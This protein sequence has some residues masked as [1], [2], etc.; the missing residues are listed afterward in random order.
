[1]T[2]V[3][4]AMIG[5]GD[6]AHRKSGPAFYLSDRSQLIAVTNR[7]IDKAHLFAS[8]HGNPQVFASVDEMLACDQ[9]DAVY[10]GT[11][12]Q[13]HCDLTLKCAAA[14][15]HVLCEKPMA[16][17]VD[18]CQTMIAACRDHNVSL[19]IAYYRRYFPVVEKIKHLVDNQAIGRILRVGVS[20]YSQFQS[21]E[22]NPWRLQRE[23]GGGGFLMDVGTHRF[24]LMA[25]LFGA[26]KRVHAVIATQTLSGSVEDAASIVMEFDHGIQ[27][28]AA[29]EWN[30]PIARDT[31]EIVGTKG[32]LWTDSLSD[33]GR[34]YLETKDGKQTFSLPASAPVHQRLVERFVGHLLDAAPNPLD[35]QSGSLATAITQA[36]Y[37]STK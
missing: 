18:D 2:N 22:K 35:G 8:H 11:P 29:F 34:L 7:S 37:Q 4:W 28:T 1:M 6:V 23:I 25:Y 32:I 13:S 10:I 31:L 19:S 17:S 26:P 33:E 20:T 36:C 27:G 16:M 30:S 14:G 9:I 5:T 15:K 21:D 12:P 24:D 3:R